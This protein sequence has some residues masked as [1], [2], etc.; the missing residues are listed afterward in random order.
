MSLKHCNLTVNNFKVL[1]N[2]WNH[3]ARELWVSDQYDTQSGDY[4]CPERSTMNIP[5]ATQSWASAQPF[6]IAFL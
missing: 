5:K 6:S 1:G 4:V 3:Y 2:C